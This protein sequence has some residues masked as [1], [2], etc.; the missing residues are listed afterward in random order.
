[1]RRLFIWTDFHLENLFGNEGSWVGGGGGGTPIT[2]TP[3]IF[4][5]FFF[6]QNSRIPVT[7]LLLCKADFAAAGH[8]KAMDVVCVIVV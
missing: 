8:L 1:M 5:F 7:E 2:Q 6:L 3:V 4:F